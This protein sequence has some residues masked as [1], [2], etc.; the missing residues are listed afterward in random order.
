MSSNSSFTFAPLPPSPQLPC[1]TAVKHCSV[2]HVYCQPSKE[3]VLVCT[4]CAA[5]IFCSS[6]CVTAGLGAHKAVR[7]RASPAALRN[8]TCGT[9]GMMYPLCDKGPANQSCASWLHGQPP[10]PSPAGHLAAHKDQR[11][12]DIPAS[13]HASGAVK[14]PAKYPTADPIASIEAMLS[15]GEYIIDMTQLQTALQR[16]GVTIVN[17]NANGASTSGKRAAE[18]MANDQN[19]RK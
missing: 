6:A 17:G 1:S 18:S 8:C 12:A 19:K 5:A 11:P 16:R 14:D 13:R 9:C 7:S 2:C 4:T 15:K 10:S 3:T